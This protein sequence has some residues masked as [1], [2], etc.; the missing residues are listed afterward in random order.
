MFDLLCRA[1]IFK[2]A[3]D[4][5]KKMPVEPNGAPGTKWGNLVHVECLKMSSLGGSSQTHF[6]FLNQKNDGIY[7]LL[8]YIYART[9]RWGRSWKNEKTYA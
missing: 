2:E 3:I 7:V 4:L 9:Q 6:I 8:S 5:I 1:G